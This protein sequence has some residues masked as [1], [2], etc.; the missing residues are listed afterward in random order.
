M[1]KMKTVDIPEG[2]SYEDIQVQYGTGRFVRTSEPG[3]KIEG[4]YRMG[5]QT[6]IGDLDEETWMAYA[7]TLIQIK[8]EVEILTNLENWFSKEL[9]WLR[10]EK[11]VH[12]YAMIFLVDRLHLSPEWVDYNAFRNK[13]YNEKE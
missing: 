6:K 2:L 4:Y 9:P 3:K 1:T 11:E 5:F 12:Q 13:F 10:D 7:E 8:G